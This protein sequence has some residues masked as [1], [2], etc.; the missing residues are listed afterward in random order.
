MGP[1]VPPS[2]WPDSATVTDA[3]ITL[4][5]LP[6]NL[7]VTSTD[8][9]GQAA[10]PA[11]TVVATFTQPAANR[12]SSAFAGSTAT[13]PGAASPTPLVVT[14]DAATRMFIAQTAATTAISPFLTP[15]SASVAVRIADAVGG[16]TATGMTTLSVADAA[17]VASS[18]QPTAAVTLGGTFS[19]PVASF[20]LPFGTD[21]DLSGQYTATINWGDG[22]TPTAGA[23]VAGLT[24]G[25][26]SVVG[27]HAY[28]GI[29]TLIPGQFAGTYPVT[30]AVQRVGVDG[31]AMTA[32]NTVQVNDLPIAVTGTLAPASI[33]GI[34]QT[35]MVTNSTTPTFVGTTEPNAT[36]TLYATMIGMSAT[37][38]V[39][40]AT[41]DATGYWS[42]TTVPLSDGAYTMAATAVDALGVASALG[43]ILPNNYQGALSV[44]TASPEVA[45][46]RFNAKTGMVSVTYTD[47]EGP[48]SLASLTNP[49][50][51][52][53]KSGTSAAAVTMASPTV[54]AA[55]P[56]G[57]SA[58]VGIRLTH[59]RQFRSNLIKL[60]ITGS[61]ITDAAGNSL[62]GNYAATVRSNSST[63][64]TAV[65]RAASATHS[66]GPTA[67]AAKL[68]AV[69]HRHG[70]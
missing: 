31:A 13:F 16:A 18:V 61:A 50:A 12:D 46:V 21:Q 29:G 20:A 10:I 15:G 52:K 38:P 8:A 54:L 68:H 66:K 67:H 5:T 24:P 48:L 9:S 65:A 4:T 14:Y 41:A 33:A 36:V 55:D 32:T 19:G 28:P 34:V 53:I 35:A 22:S 23:V 1:T 45:S 39:G 64:K 11:G 3:P 57:H 2:P 6:I 59:A 69:T 70:G 42:I 49:A 60:A 26:Y 51:Y 62:G 40:R 58:T 47:I 7:S 27:L 44:Q 30:V 43:Q 17:P 25:T 37:V 63:Q 56:L